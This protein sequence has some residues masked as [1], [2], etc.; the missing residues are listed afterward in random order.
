MTYQ[1]G[2]ITEFA[3]QHE[4][5][6]EN[7]PFSNIIKFNDWYYSDKS[8]YH[9]TKGTSKYNAK[10]WP[11]C[12]TAVSLWYFF[13]GFPLPRIDQEE[14]FCSVPNLVK[15]ADKEGWFTMAP[16]EDEIVVMDF[17]PYGTWDHTG[18]FIKWE[19]PGIS[20]WSMEA[21]TSPSE[22]GS[23]DNGGGCFK[24]LRYVNGHGMKS[25]FINVIDNVK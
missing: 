23:Q 25:K 24:R 16:E 8:E 1:R 6:T 12:A 7:P 17:A 22:K 13:G 19:V 5:E 18:I 15:M 11:Y 9:K 20:F 2:A 3:L 14:G 10:R 21:N 4:G